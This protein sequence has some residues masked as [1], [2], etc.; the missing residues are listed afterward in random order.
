M[1]KLSLYKIEAEY[2]QLAEQ[3]MDGELTPEIESALAINKENLKNKAVNYGFVCKQLES[4]VNVID[5]EIDRLSALKKQ[6]NK[7][8][9]K[10]KQ[11]L[12]DAMQLYGVEKIET[13]I[14]KI[15]FRESQSVEIDNVALIDQ[16]FMVE[17]VTVSPDKVAI[18]KAIQAGEEVI[19]AVIKVNQNIQIK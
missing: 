11:T 12:S 5:A 16:K 8:I 4:D 3:L 13:P 2:I 10:L 14:M 1:S 6:R 15:G 18:K 19:G 9:D 17:K 7:T